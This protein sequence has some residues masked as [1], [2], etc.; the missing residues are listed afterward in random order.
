MS[1][2]TQNESSQSPTNKHQWI[3]GVVRFM[4]YWFKLIAQPALAV[5]FVLGVAW[6]FGYAQRNFNWFNDAATSITDA[7][8]KEDSLYA[9]S[10]LCV[11]VKAPGR[12]PV[13][14]MELQEIEVKGDPKD[15][16]GVT[17]DPT[18]RR[19]ANIKTV[20]A[21]NLPVSKETEVLGKIAYD[22]TSEST[23][24]AYVDGRIVDLLVDFTGA[25][26]KKGEPL[27][28]LYSP[29]LYA[30]QVGLL[31]AKRLLEEN[32]S[33]NER[34]IA[35]NRKLYESA[36]R[37]LVEF[38][39]PTAQVDDIEERGEPDSNIRIV[40]PISGTCVEK[41]VK[42]GDYIKTGMPIMK[43]ADLSNV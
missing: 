27:A 26:V 22:E 4:A 24:S 16:F 33:S 34:T 13:C 11:F 17:I 43:L 2:I 12:C 1:E 5:L 10:M 39:L 23:I 35:S 9:C 3:K 14:G 19:L 38:G 36:R 30:D 42:E 15:I 20:A 8:A 28:V 21:L 7:E 37:R 40:A 18:A 32:S 29:D 41:L 25:Q 31:N 6:L